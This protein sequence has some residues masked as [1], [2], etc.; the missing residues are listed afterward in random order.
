MFYV[1]SKHTQF[2]SYP[3]AYRTLEAALAIASRPISEF[4]EVRHV[5]DCT[6]SPVGV[7]VAV[8]VRGAGHGT[9]AVKVEP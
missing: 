9:P 5:Y 6:N 2:P 1:E 8:F 4:R 3:V 7:L